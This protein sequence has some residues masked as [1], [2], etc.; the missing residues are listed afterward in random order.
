MLLAATGRDRGN[1]MRRKGYK[2]TEEHKRKIGEANAKAH[3]KTLYKIIC[4]YCG[5]YFVTRNKN[6][7]YCN[8]NCYENSKRYKIICAKCGKEFISKAHNAKFCKN[9]L[10]RKC[11]ICNKEFIISTS[12]LFGTKHNIPKKY[13]SRECYHKDS[14]GREPPNKK[15]FLII[16]CKTC[17]K[18]FTVPLRRKNTVK[19][20]SNKCRHD[21]LSK[22]TGINHPLWKGGHN[23]YGRMISENEGSFYRNRKVVLERDNYT[24]QYCR[25]QGK[26]SYM[27]VHHIIPVIEGGPNT[28]ENM[29]T[30]CRKCHNHADRKI[31]PME[32]LKQRQALIMV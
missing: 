18:E 31:I 25:H 32:L 20:C 26:S 30:L 9:C 5:E 24:C 12:E 14:I 29:I 28:P 17:S 7:I 2:L 16:I 10:A 19:Y 22:I 21:F 4:A 3:P 6:R 23:L 27:D 1:A 8:R 13:C 11:I 15:E